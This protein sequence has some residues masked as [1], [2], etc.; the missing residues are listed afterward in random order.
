MDFEDDPMDEV[1]LDGAT[2]EP[3][4]IPADSDPAPEPEAG[5]V[6]EA[7]LDDLAMKATTALA[8]A[9]AMT[10]GLQQVAGATATVSDSTERIA[11]HARGSAD[12]VRAGRDLIEQAVTEVRGL[13][14][15]SETI[16]STTKFINR[17]ADQ[18][19]LLALNATIQAARAGKAGAGFG[20]VAN[21]VKTLA[22]ETAR[23]SEDIASQVATTLSAIQGVFERVEALSAVITEVDAA[24][25]Q[26]VSGVEET[27]TELQAAAD[28]A[29]EVEEALDAVLDQVEGIAETAMG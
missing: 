17:I 6:D 8:V 18:T 26:I 19:N 16:R 13:Q 1:A 22:S 3:D 7:I 14:E 21:E 11:T 4:D 28:R 9:S 23:A 15:A 5:G 29:R 20:V 12:R 24:S 2:T 10:T 27:Q 25:H